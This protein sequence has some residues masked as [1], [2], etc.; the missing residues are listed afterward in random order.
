ME[1]K[2]TKTRKTN[3]KQ[4]ELTEVVNDLTGKVGKLEVKIDQQYTLIQELLNIVTKCLH[5]TDE[6]RNIPILL[7]KISESV[8][9]LNPQDRSHREPDS[10]ETRAAKIKRSM[11]KEWTIHLS[12]HKKWFTRYHNNSTR[13]AI[14]KEWCSREKPLLPIRLRL[15]TVPGQSKE[16]ISIRTKLAVHKFTAQI[17]SMELNA[18]CFQNRCANVN[19]DIMQLFLEKALD[20]ETL[21]KLELE[22]K[23]ECKE[24]PKRV[25]KGS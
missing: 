19:N 24:R 4:Q 10:K 9:N 5:S 15:K 6:E 21:E 11:I 7:K 16:M 8:D 2:E 17:G 14:Y 20:G 22:W 13:A 1:L 12:N 25:G 18:E 3:N 23:R